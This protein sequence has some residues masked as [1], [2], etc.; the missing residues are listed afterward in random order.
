MSAEGCFDIEEAL[1]RVDHDQ[2]TFQ[3]MIE[4]FL[5]HGPNDLRVAQ[6]ALTAGDA[7]ALARSSHRLKGAILQFCAATSLQAC[8]ELEE[9][10]KAGDLC[11]AGAIY[12]KLERELIG[13]W[14]ALRHVREK[15]MAA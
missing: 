13:L 11:R 8:T 2:E 15:G 1:E 10:A 6:V 14:T 12:P 9:S 4:L 7:T 3:M 5:E